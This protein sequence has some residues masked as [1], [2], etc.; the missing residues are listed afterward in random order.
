[1]TDNT[2]TE[3][4]A[5]ISAGSGDAADALDRIARTI[6]TV[7]AGRRQTVTLSGDSISQGGVASAT[8]PAVLGADR[9]DDLIVITDA[10]VLLVELDAPGVWLEASDD[11][12]S[13]GSATVVL[14]DA[15]VR[16]IDVSADLAERHL[17]L[18]LAA[19]LIR[20]ANAAYALARDYVREREQFG[21]PLVAMPTVAANLARLQVELQRME[22]AFTRAV[23]PDAPPASELVLSAVVADASGRAARLAHQLNGARGIREDYPLQIHTRRIWAIRDLPRG[24]F[25]D[26]EDLGRRARLGGESI[27]WDALTAST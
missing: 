21:S 27:V 10:S 17:R 9:A 24:Q 6:A 26:T 19:V 13:I 18:A 11:L 3:A 5:A 23:T 14:R 12:G 16:N 7:G 4:L 25:V 1:M 20:N 22:A 2:L 15:P 8:M